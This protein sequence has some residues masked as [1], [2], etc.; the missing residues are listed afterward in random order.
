MNNWLIMFDRRSM[1]LYS[2]NQLE[3]N[4]S[5]EWL[6]NIPAFCKFDIILQKACLEFAQITSRTTDAS[7]LLRAFP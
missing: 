3:D 2:Q 1:V 7:L 4:K 5:I 6:Q